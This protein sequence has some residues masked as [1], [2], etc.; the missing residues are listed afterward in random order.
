MKTSKTLLRKVL[1]S[2]LVAGVVAAVSWVIWD[3]SCTAGYRQALERYTNAA[4]AISI[5][6]IRPRDV[7]A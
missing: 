2:F 4:L 7:P 3:A 5:Q 1:A 6:D